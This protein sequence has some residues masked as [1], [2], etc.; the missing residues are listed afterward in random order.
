M[1]FA[2]RLEHECGADRPEKRM[3]LAF[4]LAFGRVPDKEERAAARQFLRL[5]QQV[6]AKDKDAELR[7]WTDFCQMM[8]AC[9]AFLYVE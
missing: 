7:L 8:L 5:Q 1:E 3:A 2:R 6:Y 4:Q 9:N